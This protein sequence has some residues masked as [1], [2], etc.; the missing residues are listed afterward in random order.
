MTSG[1]KEQPATND[2]NEKENA[3]V[4]ANWGSASASSS[5]SAGP[6]T[7]PE[8]PEESVPREATPDVKNNDPELRNRYPNIERA[9]GSRKSSSTRPGS[10]KGM[11][12][13]MAG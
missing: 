5:S 7:Q 1:P 13:L 6:A 4:P 12:S 9:S 10:Q 2:D 8:A 3:P 11:N